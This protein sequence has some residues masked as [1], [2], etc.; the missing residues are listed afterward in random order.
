MEGVVSQ[1]ERDHLVKDG[2]RL[3]GAR[4]HRGAHAVVRVLLAV[5]PRQLLA[6]GGGAVA[7]CGELG[8]VHAHRLAKRAETD[9]GDGRRLVRAPEDRLYELFALALQHRLKLAV[10]R[11]ERILEIGPGVTQIRA[12][13]DGRL[14]KEFARRHVGGKRLPARLCVVTLAADDLARHEQVVA[15]GVEVLENALFR[16][17]EG[18]RTCIGRFREGF[19]QGDGD[20]IR[21]L[22][23]IRVERVRIAPR[24][25]RAV[26]GGKRF[27]E[28]CPVSPLR[29]ALN[30]VHV[31][32][33]TQDALYPLFVLLRPCAAHVPGDLLPS[34]D[35]IER[36]AGAGSREDER[37]RTEEGGLVD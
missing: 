35:Q 6:C 37:Q 3:R 24:K 21:D 30:V 12:W 29:G 16:V 25:H 20:E 32:Q 13:I 8:I 7:P 9:E 22:L 27:L 28:L 1:T 4:S 11:I 15:K 14:E 10:V 5:L 23:R 18:V 2:E 26:G 36:D 31:L 19:R 33:E 17:P 34:L